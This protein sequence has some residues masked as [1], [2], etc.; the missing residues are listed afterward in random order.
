MS[1]IWINLRSLYLIITPGLRA[2]ISFLIQYLKYRYSFTFLFSVTVSYSYFSLYQYW[3]CSSNPLLTA[4][5]VIKTFKASLCLIRYSL[6]AGNLHSDARRYTPSTHFPHSRNFAESMCLP[7]FFFQ[8]QVTLSSVPAN[9][10][11]C[12]PSWNLCCTSA[13]YVFPYLDLIQVILLMFLYILQ[14]SAGL[15]LP[16]DQC[17]DILP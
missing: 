9:W 17:F 16:C 5:V 15:P 11:L 2:V 1:V 8:P 7:L 10:I 4:H 3:S 13:I 12:L 6:P 14:Y